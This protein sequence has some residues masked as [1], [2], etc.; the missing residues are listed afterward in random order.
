MAQI[1]MDQLLEDVTAVKSK[2]KQCIPKLHL[3]KL[4]K[5]KNVEGRKRAKSM[6]I[7][8]HNQHSPTTTTTTTSK[9]VTEEDINKILDSLC[10]LE[11][12][13]ESILNHPMAIPQVLSSSSQSMEGQPTSTSLASFSLTPPIGVETTSTTSF[14]TSMTLTSIM[15]TTL[16]QAEYGLVPNSFVFNFNEYVNE[17]FDS[18][19]SPTFTMSDPVVRKIYTHFY[20]RL[21]LEITDRTLITQNVSY[22]TPEQYLTHFIESLRQLNLLP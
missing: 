1:M 2:K 18:V 17:I 21:S 9:M 15:P 19:I 20:R 16:N 22:L 11:Q 4:K 10:P 14:P 12:T 5:P 6:R 3:S 8:N 7:S 13:Q